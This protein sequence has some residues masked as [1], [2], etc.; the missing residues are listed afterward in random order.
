M[1]QIPKGG[2][3]RRRKR[4]PSHESADQKKMDTFSF[5]GFAIPDDD[6]GGSFKLVKSIIGRYLYKQITALLS[7]KKDSTWQRKM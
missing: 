3:G 4:N 5:C 1:N 2:G 7:Q 6:G